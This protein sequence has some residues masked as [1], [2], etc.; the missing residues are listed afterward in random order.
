MQLLFRQV[1]RETEGPAARNDRHLVQ[2]VRARDG[3]A[4]E[5]V[6]RLVIGDEATLLVGEHA[7]LPLEAEHHLVLRVL[8]VLAVHLRLVAARGQQRG[9]VHDVRE[10]RAGEAGRAARDALEVH[11]RRHRN[12]AHV[13]PQDLLAAFQVG[14]VDDD[15][16]V[17]APGPQQRGIQDVGAIRGGEQD[18]A[19]VGFKAVHLDEQLVQGLLALVMAAAQA[20]ATMAADRVDLVDE[21]D[22]RRVLLALLEQIAHARGAHADEHFDEIRTGHREEGPAGFAGDRLGE[23]RLAGARRADE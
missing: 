11:A 14:H 7:A 4:Y 8:E 17:E 18:D 21:N 15:L 13:D 19:L 5:R 16:A 22:A 9:F 1:R 20:R 6:A 10:L 12:L 3:K 2:R 23:Q